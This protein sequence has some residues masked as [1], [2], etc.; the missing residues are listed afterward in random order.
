MKNHRRKT[1]HKTT[2]QRLLRWVLEVLWIID[3]VETRWWDVE[4]DPL[5]IIQGEALMAALNH[6]R[7]CA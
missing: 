1:M 2:K 6:R 5:N 4:D 3:P 7:A